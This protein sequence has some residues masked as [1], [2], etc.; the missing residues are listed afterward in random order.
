MRSARRGR[1]A[2]LLTRAGRFQLFRAPVKRGLELVWDDDED[3]GDDD[4]IDEDA[5][6][7]EPGEPVDDMMGEGV[8]FPP[9]GEED[10]SWEDEEEPGDD[11]EED[12]DDGLEEED[13]D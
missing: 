8:G 4:E 5:G 2:G 3:F 7:D 6:E 12:D 11:E 13:E 9:P 10:W 1:L